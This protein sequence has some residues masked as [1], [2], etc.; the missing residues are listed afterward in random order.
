MRLRGTA[1]INARNHLEIGG[2]DTVELARRFGTPLYV[3]DEALI[4][5]NCRA[6][7][8]AFASEAGGMVLYAAKTFLTTGMARLVDEEGLGLDVVSGG[9]LYTALAAGF[10]SERIYFNGNNKS[11]A[12]LE[13][14]LAARIGGVV[15]DNPSELALLSDLAARRGQRVAVLLRIAPGVQAHTHEY[16]Q[17]GQADSKFGFPL[18]GGVALAGVKEALSASHLDLRGYHC[19]IGSQILALESYRAAVRAML[20]FAAEARAATGYAPEVLDLGGGLG[21]RY[22]ADDDPPPIE[23]LARTMR[24]AVAEEAAAHGLPCPT[25]FVEPGRSIV[26]EAGTTLYTVGAIKDIP[27]VRRY[28][29][30]DGGMTDNP[31]VAL[32]QAVYEAIVANRAADA[33]SE[34]VS[35][36][37][38]CCESGD[39]LLWDAALPPVER[40]DLLAVFTTGAYNYSMASNYNRLPRPAVVLV[41][42]GRARLLVARETYA[43]LI[44]L[45]LIPEDLARP[46]EKRLPAARQAP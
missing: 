18:V 7:R 8:E 19:H 16:I 43:D 27:G 26:G 22:T 3:M 6:Y 15:V 44:R 31:R 40:G 9:E 39:M 14:A 38:K 5:E 32:Y 4:R 29:A 36:A 37:G 2:C 41:G 1:R 11:P 28:V 17:T 35:V 10:P 24:A 34:V 33:P 30:V 42:G 12:E 23:E 20:E 46:E 13:E 21:A 45:D 25:I